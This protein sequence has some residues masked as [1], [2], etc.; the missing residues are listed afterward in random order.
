M[1]AD[2]SYDRKCS[3]CS[4]QVKD[5]TS[6]GMADCTSLRHQRKLFCMMMKFYDAPGN[7]DLSKKKEVF[8][9]ALSKKCFLKVFCRFLLV[10]WGRD[11]D[12]DD[13]EVVWGTG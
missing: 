11:E 5:T 6:H 1:L 13:I 7:I 12:L 8:T 3:H 2:S 10:I 9:L 4:K